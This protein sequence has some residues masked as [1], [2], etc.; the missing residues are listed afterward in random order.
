VFTVLHH[1]GLLRLIFAALPFL[2]A[3][4]SFR[5]APRWIAWVAIGLAILALFTNAIVT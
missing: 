5:H 1:L 4:W 2:W 3:V